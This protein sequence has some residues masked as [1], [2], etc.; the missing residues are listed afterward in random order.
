MVGRI[1]NGF[2]KFTHESKVT[3]SKYTNRV[4][5]QLSDGHLTLRCNYI[6]DRGFVQR[7]AIENKNQC[8]MVEKPKPVT[9]AHKGYKRLVGVCNFSI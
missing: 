1:H 2:Y 8:I 4:N 9:G 5:R 7:K 6:M 3:D